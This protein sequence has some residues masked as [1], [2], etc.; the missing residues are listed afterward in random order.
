MAKY[1]LS[2]PPTFPTF[3][4]FWAFLLLFSY[5]FAFSP[6]FLLFEEKLISYSKKPFSTFILT[7]IFRGSAPVQ[8]L[9]LYKHSNKT[10][11]PA[12]IDLHCCILLIQHFPENFAL[13]FFS[14][15]RS[16]WSW[17]DVPAWAS[18]RASMQELWG[19]PS[20]WGYSEC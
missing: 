15:F 17:F 10:V 3:P 20:V 13:L 8:F 6:T 7:K 18:G 14:V 16:F 11:L 19:L 2:R 4:T 1:R 9:T 12:N 5:F